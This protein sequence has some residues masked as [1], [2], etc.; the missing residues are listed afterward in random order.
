MTATEKLEVQ[1]LKVAELRAALGKRGLSAEGLKADLIT[2][3]QARLDEEEYGLVDTPGPASTGDIVIETSTADPEA[4]PPSSENDTNEVET[5]VEPV[6]TAES[7]PPKVSFTEPHLEVPKATTTGTQTKLSTDVSTS[8]MSFEEKKKARAKRFGIPLVE[9]KHPK[10]LTPN[11]REGDSNSTRQKKI[12]KR[13]RRANS[14]TKKDRSPKNGD[15]APKSKIQDENLSRE[16]IEKR[17][18]RA[19][20]FKMGT[21]VTDPLKAMLRKHRFNTAS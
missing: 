5:A 12:D 1:K 15:D 11:K 18:A 13:H 10:K 4:P 16:E 3:L 7:S 21:E 17:L 6:A 20:K 14:Q 9:N 19:E 2:R 8:V